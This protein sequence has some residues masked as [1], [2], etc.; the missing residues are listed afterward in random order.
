MLNGED[1]LQCSDFFALRYLAPS[2]SHWFYYR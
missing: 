1:I 2:D